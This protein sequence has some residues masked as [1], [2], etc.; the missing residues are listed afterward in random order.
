MD[1]DPARLLDWEG[2]YGGLP[3]FDVATPR[4]IEAAAELAIERTRANIA[5]IT[6]ERSAPTFENTILAMEAG[7]VHLRRIRALFHAF[8]NTAAT[9]EMPDVASRVAARFSA[10]E[11]EI[12]HDDALFARVEAVH[13]AAEHA[14]PEQRRLTQV[15]HA[16]MVRRG[17]RLAPPQRERFAEINRQ[18]AVLQTRFNQNLLAEQPTQA[19]V[20]DRAQ[21]LEGLP[22]AALAAAAEAA[23]ARGCDGAWVIENTRAAVWP[24]LAS[25]SDRQTR[26]QVRDMWVARGGH[27]GPYDNRP[28]IRE[29]LCLRREK[30]RLLGYPSFAHFAT[31]D[32]M[33]ETPERA[34]Q[35]LRDVWEVV[36]RVT[37]SQQAELQ[38]LADADGLGGPIEAHDR[39]YYAE[40]LRQSRFGLTAESIRPYLALDSVLAALFDAARRLHDLRFRALP[41]A[42]VL[43][44]DIRVFEITRHGA[45]IGL[46]W[47]DLLRREGKSHGSWQQEYR[48]AQAGEPPVIA[49]VSVNS[50][51]ERDRATG[52]VLMGWEYANVL[53]H[54][55]GHA[56]HMLMCRARYAALGS[57]KVA[58]D[59]IELPSLLF[60]RWLPDR[61]LLC[62]HLRHHVTGL[63]IPASLIDGIE[64]AARF[65]RVFSVQLE[66]LAAAIID[67]RLHLATADG[68][69]DP[70]A[71]QAGTRA[72]L[73][74]PA[75]IDL[76]MQ[77]P[78]FVHIATDEYA[79]GVYSYLWS[80]V[81]AADVAEAFVEAPGG[82]Y[83]AQVA[84]RWR[85]AILSVGNTVPARQAYR[86]FR[87]RD[88]DP[89]PLLR[90]FDLSPRDPATAT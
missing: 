39:A 62:R 40:K 49:L 70:L 47:F 88:P 33:A 16:Q 13:D 2:P 15:T 17:A 7:S 54:E 19:V 55:F 23:R 64:A 20:V 8:A 41:E 10:I 65:D 14:G 89:R 44:P 27:D 37:A 45:V 73:G 26:R 21:A 87:G 60:E 83:D 35:L 30:A 36:A 63:P 76:V 68:A 67:M 48:A 51:L 18:I 77:V 43:H 82:L 85:E 69:I 79:A 5:F 1:A 61:D 74:M 46:V 11:D 86:N 57:G 56:L 32:R 50:S 24:V 59:L 84:T 38:A 3:A 53:F 71:V 6:G 28:V 34:L 4:L 72:E 12:A 31:A 42:P 66:F 80:D 78:N 29:L 90:R 22:A 75:A 58:W 9:G 81:M 25:V 52:D